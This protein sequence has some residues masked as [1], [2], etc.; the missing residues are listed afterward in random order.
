MSTMVLVG[1]GPSQIRDS[2]RRRDGTWSLGRGNRRRGT[3]QADG[4]VGTRMVDFSGGGEKKI[5]KK[6]D[7]KQNLVFQTDKQHD[8]DV[9]GS[10]VEMVLIDYMIDV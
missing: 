4:V 5:C 3:R 9:N 6:D 10:Q 8:D 7:V 1:Q 2:R